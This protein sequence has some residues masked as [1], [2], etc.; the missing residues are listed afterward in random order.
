MGAI[1][2][3]LRPPAGPSA[4]DP[5][6][7]FGAGEAG[8]WY[9]PGDAAS[10]FADSGRR[11]PAAIDGEVGGLADRSGRGHHLAQEA[12]G[13]RPILRRDAAGRRCLDFDGVDDCLTS[14]AAGLCLTGPVTIAAAIRRADGE[15]YDIWTSAQTEA[16]RTNAY[17][18]RTDPSGVLEFVAAHGGGFEADRAD[19]PSVLPVAATRVVTAMR[20]SG[21]I[22]FTVGGVAS[23]AA[24]GLVPTADAASEFRLGGRKGAP[25]FARGRI[26][27]AIVVGRMLT[28]AE[29]AA[30]RGWLTARAG[31]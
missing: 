20:T 30:I 27:G 1:G 17:E 4:F 11:V 10:T 8:G 24:H 7:L 31:A 15:R 16:G 22:D 21:T 19:G 26:Y 18:L 13:A 25:L 28:G 23:S 2:F 6:L 14:S 29:L 12:A 9:D 3:A 5:R